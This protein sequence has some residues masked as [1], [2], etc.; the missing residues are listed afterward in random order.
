MQVARPTRTFATRPVRN[1]APA[2]CVGSSSKAMIGNSLRSL[3]ATTLTCLA[4]LAAMSAVPTV[5]GAAGAL[6]GNGPLALDG[7]IGSG[8]AL[9]ASAPVGNGPGVVA[10]NPATHTLYVANGFNLN[11]P[12]AGD[13]T[14]S[15]I[16]ARHCNAHN[17][18]RCKGRWPTI[19]V[20]NATRSLST[21]TPTACT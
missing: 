20:R 9:V 18:S 8:S 4:L 7:P 13:N 12:E 1:V 5:A 2:C 16:D 11:G 19:T 14:I 6:A 17:V 10:L 3:V 15:V 21:S